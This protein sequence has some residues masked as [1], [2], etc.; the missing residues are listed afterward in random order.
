[1]S[2]LPPD[3][4][5]RFRKWEILCSVGHLLLALASTGLMIYAQYLWPFGPWN[6]YPFGPRGNPDSQYMQAPFFGSGGATFIYVATGFT[7]VVS[8]WTF[9]L[10]PLSSSLY[11]KYR[12]LRCMEVIAFI[13]WCVALAIIVPKYN[14]SQER[15]WRR[16]KL[17]DVLNEYAEN[18]E[19]IVAATELI[20]KSLSKGHISLGLAG[21]IM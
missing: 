13:L 18:E 3:P 19:V 1:M 20:D 17:L 4:Y 5:A 2:T 9:I 16:Y 7:L 12:I 15:W 21:G 8:I 6:I 11:T 10:C 14:L